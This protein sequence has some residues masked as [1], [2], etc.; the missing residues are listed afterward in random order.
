MHLDQVA[1]ALDS[2]SFTYQN[3]FKTFWKN[4]PFNVK[5]HRTWY[6]LTT[7]IQ[8]GVCVGKTEVW[9]KHPIPT[10]IIHLRPLDSKTATQLETHIDP[11]L[12]QIRWTEATTLAANGMFYLAM[13][14]GEHGLQGGMDSQICLAVYRR[15]NKDHVL[16]FVT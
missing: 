6:N 15:P 7:K 10:L 8:D 9:H 13:G 4:N 16:E 2:G 14:R 5:G 11:N 12:F 3:V 1:E